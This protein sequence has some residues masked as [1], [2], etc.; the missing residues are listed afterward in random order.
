M[1]R[2]QSS[3]RRIDGRGYP[4]YKDLKGSYR[5]PGF[6]LEIA[7][8]QGDPF[9]APS[10]LELRA[11]VASVAALEGLGLDRASRRVGAE[12]ALLRS[13]VQA[14]PR[15]QSRGSGKSGQWGA[16]RPGQEMLPRS[17]CEILG[18][19][20]HVRFTVGLPAQGRRVLGRQAAQMLLEELPELVQRGLLRADP[21]RVRAHAEANEDQ[22]ALRGM[23]EE[24]G[25]VGF[26]AN[27]AVLPRRS[28]VDDRPLEQGALPWASPGEALVEFTLP[29]AGLVRGS[30][31]AQGVTLICGGGYHGKSTVLRALARGVYNHIPGDG[32]QL[33]VS[34]EDAVQVRAEDGRSISGV[35]ISGFI[36][37]LPDGRSTERFG[38]QNASG[39]T[40]QA[41]AIAEALEMDAGCLLIDEDTSATNF[42][43]RDRRMQALIATAQE[44]ITPF[45]DRVAQLD[46]VLGVSTVLVVGGSGDYFQVADH[47]WVMEGY[48]PRLAT[49]QARRI[50]L[51]HPSGRLEEARAPLEVPRDRVPLARSFDARR[52][53]RDKVRARDTRSISLGEQEID[54][55]LLAQLVDDG[56]ARTLGDWLLLCGRELADGQTC[57]RD[58]CAEIEERALRSSLSSTT[59]P[60][61]GDRVFVRRFELAAAINRLR[62]L[63]LA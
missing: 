59:R 23:L 9:A 21:A 41:A 4:A 25:L 44:P 54:T 3:L 35:D 8:V 1:E 32:R 46:R 34:V 51:E 2:L 13:F 15:G 18:D 48:R 62:S 12:D 42:M 58:L 52:G 20:V 7:H 39:S 33:C 6:V 24:R 60:F 19:Q 37:S 50:A 56:Q 28:G 11:P 5:F 47:V 45:V 49:E 43:V 53:Q 38:S 36:G 61:A 16:A 10:L 26:V 30:G 57:L 29:N 31:F 14:L 17:G 40:S 27:G 63:V 22:D 55:S